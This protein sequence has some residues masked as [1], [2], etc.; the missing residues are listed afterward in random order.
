R[1]LAASFIRICRQAGFETVAQWLLA[2]LQ[3]CPKRHNRAIVFR[4]PVSLCRRLLDALFE[5][6]KDEIRLDAQKQQTIYD[7]IV[8]NLR[9][10]CESLFVACK[11]LN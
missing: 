4:E 10:N 9:K 3:K 6:S 1:E 5:G 8:F 2:L 11:I 7:L